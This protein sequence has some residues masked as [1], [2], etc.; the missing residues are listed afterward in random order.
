MKSMYSWVLLMAFVFVTA[1]AAETCTSCPP[2]NRNTAGTIYDRDG[3]GQVT[4]Q[5][6]KPGAPVKNTICD[7]EKSNNERYR[8]ARW[9]LYRRTFSTADAPVIKITGRLHSCSTSA[10][11][12]KG[13]TCASNL[14]GDALESDSSIEI[15]V[16][17]ARPDGTYSSLRPG[18]GDGDC[19]STIRPSGGDS[20]Y[21]ETLAPGSMGMLSG[22]GPGGWDLPPYGPGVVNFLIR[23]EGHPPLLANVEVLRDTFYGPDVRGHALVGTGSRRQEDGSVKISSWTKD[24][25]GDISMEVDFFLRSDSSDSGSAESLEN[26]MCPALVYGLPKSFFTQPIALCAPS[27]LDFFEM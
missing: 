11:D 3:G 24:K 25:N 26:I 2:S 22:I 13:S 18:V 20:F 15:E 10:D 23:S 6:Y 19:R 8:V 4:A 27:L 17:Q 5:A 12:S 21:V 7:V 16:W 14:I 9:P 1:D